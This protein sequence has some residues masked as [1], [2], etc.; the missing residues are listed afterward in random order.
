VECAG[1]SLGPKGRHGI[2]APIRAR[3]RSRS[4]LRPEGPALMACNVISHCFCAA[5]SVLIRLDTVLIHALTGVAIACRPFGPADV[6]ELAQR[7]FRR[8]T[9]FVINE[10]CAE[11]PSVCRLL[12]LQA[13]SCSDSPCTD[14]Q[15]VLLKVTSLKVGR[16]FQYKNESVP[17]RNLRVPH[18]RTSH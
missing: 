2:A 13:A 15:P 5:P 8:A 14:W 17:L 12:V 16:T 10:T 3:S 4:I 7:I 9:T 6:S 18:N 11:V 1:P